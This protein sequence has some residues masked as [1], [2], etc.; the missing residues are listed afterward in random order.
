MYTRIGDTHYFISDQLL[1]DGTISQYWCITKRKI[2]PQNRVK[3]KT[4]EEMCQKLFG[5]VPKMLHPQDDM[6]ILAEMEIR[7][8]TQWANAGNDSTRIM[9]ADGR[10]F[11]VDL[12]TKELWE[13]SE[14][15]K[16]SHD[17]P[18]FEEAKEWANEYLSR[19]QGELF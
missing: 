6:E 19:I 1:S 5:E 14:I 4:F 9:E 2:I 10:H 8:R 16:I 12:L 11:A 15:E 3:S 18:T 17:F 13:Y 7:R